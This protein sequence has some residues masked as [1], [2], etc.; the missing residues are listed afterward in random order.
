M[1][2]EARDQ[3]SKQIIQSLVHYLDLVF[4]DLETFGAL[5]LLLLC[6]DNSHYKAFHD[7]RIDI[8]IFNRP[9]GLLSSGS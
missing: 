3:L 1:L 5:F 6:S 7:T 8:H 2:F 4:C 9:Y